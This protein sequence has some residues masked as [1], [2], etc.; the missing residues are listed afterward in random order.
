[1][2][3]LVSTVTVG[4]GG[5]ASI[6]FT[7]IAGSGKDLLVVLSCRSDSTGEEVFLSLNSTTTGYS[8]RFL[9]GANTNVFSE[10][11][12]NRSLGYLIKTSTTTAN[13][14]GSASIYI[15][16]YSSSNNKSISVDYVVE[17]NSSNAT[18]GITASQWAN[19]SAITSLAL[20][21]TSGNNFVQY[22]TASLY[23]IS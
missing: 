8:N 4:S 15:T 23:I 10:A 9:Y 1:M 7:G 2:M 5:A 21:P 14:F 6:E 13:T 19:S 20:S 16:N 12:S 17:N 18:Q 3:E 22:S 11:F